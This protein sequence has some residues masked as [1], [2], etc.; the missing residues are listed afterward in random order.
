[1]D[2]FLEVP[3]VPHGGHCL[4]VSAP[5]EDPDG[6]VL[7]GDHRIH[8][9]DPGGHRQGQHHCQR[10]A[11]PLPGRGDPALPASPEADP[12]DGAAAM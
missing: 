2:Y 1:M 10:G 6:E 5:A 11:G 9:G 8:R 12:E 4:P 3:L 7:R